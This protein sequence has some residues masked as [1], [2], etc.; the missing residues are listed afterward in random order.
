[1]V[2]ATG[3]FERNIFLSCVVVSGAYVVMRA[4]LVPWVND[5]VLTY[6][7]FIEP[8]DIVP[9]HAPWD[10][11]NHFLNSALGLAVYKVF[12]LVRFGSRIGNVLAFALY[13]WATFQLGRRVQD[14]LVRWCLWG[15]LLFCPFIIEFFSL[16]RGYGMELAFWLVGTEVLIRL[17]ERWRLRLFVLSM[18][19]LLLAHAAVLVTVPLWLTVLLALVV[20]A[21]QQRAGMSVRERRQVIC[22]WFFLGLVP[23]V[24]AAWYSFELREHDALYW[25]SL[26]GFMEVTMRSLLH[27]VFGNGDGAAQ[28][29]VLV[30]VILAT[31]SVVWGSKGRRWL[32]VVPA[33]LWTDSLSSVA[34]AHILELNYPM[35]RTAAHL[36]PWTILVLALALGRTT[37]RFRIARFASL[38]LLWLPFR[39]AFTAN[40]EETVLWPGQS[41]PDRLVQRIAEEEAEGPKL[42]GGPAHE[43]LS[44]AYEAR[45]AGLSAPR[46]ENEL[47]GSPLFELRLVKGREAARQLANYHAIDSVPSVGQ[48][49][50]ARNTPLHLLLELE[51]RTEAVSGTWEYL[52]LLDGDAILDDQ[53]RILEVTGTIDSKAVFADL[54]VVV[55][56]RGPD[57]EQAYYEGYPLRLSRPRWAGESFKLRVR[58]PAVPSAT[59]CTVYIWN[60]RKALITTGPIM[61]TM[62]R[63][64][65]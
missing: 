36:V 12:G 60:P 38:I 21:W 15:A 52:G 33:L 27:F 34:M 10:A 20:L 45:R 9:F 61:V 59:T 6:F 22:A 37:P 53:D 46:I 3:R 42:L 13:A 29:T 43:G 55:S 32:L 35:D 16:F 40:V 54:N 49:L 47:S 19:A 51:H 5:E 41:P 30:V 23:W 64:A 26:D 25:G 17:A 8:G 63:P 58:L 14:R 62:Y 24:G 56:M 1:M 28:W 4:A 18:L 44:I 2:T 48:Y 11:N 65:P 50:L 39:W 57:G 7:L 31:A